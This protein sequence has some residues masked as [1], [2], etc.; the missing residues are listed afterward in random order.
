M[1]FSPSISLHGV[2]RYHRRTKGKPRERL[3]LYSL[4]LVL[5]SDFT[6]RRIP[7]YEQ[8]NS[9][10]H[11]PDLRVFYK[12]RLICEVEVTG[13]DIPWN[14]LKLKGWIFVLPS[15]VRYAHKRG[16]EYVFC[17]FNDA[18]FPCGEWLL[19]MPGNE[20]AA[21]AE[22]ARLAELKW[23][24]QTVHGVHEKFYM[25]PKKVF[26]DGEGGRGLLSLAHYLKWLAGLVPDPN[27]L[28]LVN[29]MG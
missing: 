6:V 17:V 22:L 29:F 1:S 26:R 18:E 28:A 15:K 16:R 11:V 14:K 5:G 25:L 9:S 4:R 19:W 2:Y 7:A 27:P 24:G 8:R 20:L 3:V 13:L 12:S 21:H 23:E 10:E